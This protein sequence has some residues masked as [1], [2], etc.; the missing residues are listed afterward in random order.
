MIKAGGVVVEA[1]RGDFY[2]VDVTIGG[3]TSRVLARRG[4]RLVENRIR[5]VPGDEVEVELSPYDPRRG[6]IVYRGRRDA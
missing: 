3:A 5:L 4:G 1:H 2:D 6:R